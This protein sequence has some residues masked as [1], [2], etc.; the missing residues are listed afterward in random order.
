MKNAFTLIE[1]IAVIA[2][3]GLIALIVYPSVNSVIKSAKDDSYESQIKIIEKAA[4]E[5]SL[6][7]IN[8]LSK[9]N[10][11]VV[12]VSQLV[13]GGYISNEDVKD[14]RDT[15]KSLTGGVE[16]SYSSKDYIYRYNEDATSCS[17]ASV[18]VKNSG[19]IS[20]DDL[21]VLKSQ[22]GYYK[23]SNPNNYL[24]YG[25]MEWR[26]LK[27]ND[28]GSLKII[29][30]NGI[31]LSISDTDFKNSSLSS[32]L[33]TSFYDSIE[34]NSKISKE[35]YCLN[36]Q[37]DCFENDKLKVTVMNLNDFMEASNNLNC[38]ESSLD[39]CY[40]GNY[41]LDYSENNGEEYTLIRSG[42]DDL[43]LNKGYLSNT[44]NETKSV[45]PIVTLNNI[46]ILK[47]NGSVQ[48][49]YVAV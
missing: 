8:L 5:W 29:S 1:L 12:C 14:P 33:N 13:E 19:V 26:I 10:V 6:D 31:T 24:D 32:Y 40:Q 11:T 41:L 3:L 45:R 16:I 49:P 27:V 30:N 39:A 21:I 38:S 37:D 46:N 48:N 22:D 47:G 43:S 34:K 20:D 25:N 9:E 23:G 18:G 4:R 7:N 42:N 2:I 15:S 44:N 28:D 17:G 35:K 36:Y